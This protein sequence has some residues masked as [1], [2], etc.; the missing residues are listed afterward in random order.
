M[1]YLELSRLPDTIGLSPYFVCSL[2]SVLRALHCQIRRMSNRKGY[3]VRSIL[4]IIPY[5]SV[6]VSDDATMH[7]AVVPCHACPFTGP[8]CQP[9]EM[10]SGKRDARCSSFQNGR[11]VGAVINESLCPLSALS[12]GNTEHREGPLEQPARSPFF[13]FN[14]SY[15]STKPMEL[16]SSGN[17]KQRI[18]C[19]SYCCKTM[20]AEYGVCS[21]VFF[22]SLMEFAQAPMMCEVRVRSKWLQPRYAGP[23]RPAQ[24]QERERR[25]V[26]CIPRTVTVLSTDYQVVYM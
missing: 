18:G 23:V 11:R 21:S 15:V 14:S 4:Q 25:A 6:R 1:E 3:G 9:L 7:Y 10:G 16:A 2:Y 5:Y 22:H 20:Y 12:E 26:V 13:L 17:S 19:T 8:L 24:G